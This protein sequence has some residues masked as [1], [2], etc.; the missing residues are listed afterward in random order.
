[1]HPPI[2]N[3]ATVY[4]KY[5][6]LAQNAGPTVTQQPRQRPREN[7][8]SLIKNSHSHG[9]RWELRPWFAQVKALRIFSTY[10]HPRVSHARYPDK[11]LAL[12]D[13]EC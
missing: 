2:I 1:M 9:R 12:T 8:Y 6:R 11:T 4:K 5:C 7:K 3:L 10:T 13:H